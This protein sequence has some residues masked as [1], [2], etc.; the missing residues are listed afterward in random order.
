MS[1]TKYFY[2][3]IRTF[4]YFIIYSVEFRRKNI[5]ID[6][7]RSLDQENGQRESSTEDM[8]SRFDIYG[9]TP[10]RTRIKNKNRDWDRKQKM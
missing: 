5:P 9:S 6:N 4:L 10:P 7:V 1:H 2:K 8:I 3:I